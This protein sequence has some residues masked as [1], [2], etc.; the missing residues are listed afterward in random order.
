MKNDLKRFL[1]PLTIAASASISFLAQAQTNLMNQGQS[2]QVVQGAPVSLKEEK[3]LQYWDASKPLTVGDMS[4]I[5]RKKMA[6]DFLAQNG[7]TTQEQPKAVLSNAAKPKP[8]PPPPHNLQV[9][10]VYG[11]KRAPSADVVFDGVVA[12]VND[13]SILKSD[14]LVVSIKKNVEGNLVAYAEKLPVKKC[15]SSKKKT[16]KPAVLPNFHL[17]AGES[18]EWTR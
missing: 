6:E 15:K 12:T 7:F 2:A 8:L 14:R 13:G 1:L 3:K 16:C 9:R 17:L 10:A 4:E 11:V 18:V 5:H